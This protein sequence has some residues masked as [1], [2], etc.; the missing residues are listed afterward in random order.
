[1]QTVAAWQGDSSDAIKRRNKTM[2][3]EEEEGGVGLGIIMI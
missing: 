3:K 1:L 2:T